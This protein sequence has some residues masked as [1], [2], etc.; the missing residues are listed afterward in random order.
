MNSQLNDKI[1]DN[2]INYVCVY[3]DYCLFWL[4]LTLEMHTMPITANKTIPITTIIE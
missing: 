1:Y 2:S 4:S 3:H